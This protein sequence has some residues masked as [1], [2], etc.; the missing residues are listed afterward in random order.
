MVVS[1]EGTAETDD[2]PSGA[3]RLIADTERLRGKLRITVR[4]TEDG[5]GIHIPPARQ[6]PVVAFMLLWMGGWAAGEYFAI[7]ELLS[8]G[9]RL[10]GLFVLLWLV[11]WT[12]GG[13]GVFWVICW[14]L[15]G[16]ERLFFT[17]GALVREWSLLGFGG[18]RVL[19]GSDIVSVSVDD[20][21]S[22]D[23]AGFGTIKVGTA[24][25]TMRI[26]SGLPDYEAQL[27]AE[28]IRQAVAGNERPDNAPPQPKPA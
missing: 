1:G 12:L 16:V 15:F 6:L 22:N 27:V 24:G 2:A 5:L 23:L 17:A 19:H 11:P 13:A 4:H 9:F 7:G 25:R 28:L 8:S 20:K 21:A 10:P 18:R 14:Q 26:G 3:A